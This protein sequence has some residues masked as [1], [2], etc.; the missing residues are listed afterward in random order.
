MKQSYTAY[1]MIVIL[2]S[3]FFTLFLNAQ[4]VE[5]RVEIIRL[6]DHPWLG[7]QISDASDTEGL[8]AKHG[9]YVNDVVADSPADS[10][11]LRIG[12]V[13]IRFGEVEI[14]EAEDLTRAVGQSE[15]NEPVGIVVIRDGREQRLSVT[16]R[17]RP[18]RHALRMPPPHDRQR[19]VI[20][21]N[22]GRLGVSV[23]NLSSQLR[24]Y[25]KVP[26]GSGVLVEKVHAETP[27]EKAGIRAGDVI[28]KVGDRNIDT[29]R[30]L[31]RVLSTYDA[32]EQI[33]V[34]LIREGTKRTVTAQLE[35]RSSTEFYIP[36][37][38]REDL[39]FRIFGPGGA[40]EFRRNLEESI[41]PGLEDLRIQLKEH[42]NEFQIKIPDRIREVSRQI[43]I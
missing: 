10:A 19:I 27:A 24:E 22:Y 31:R 42:F 34:E 4:K 32:G 30:R 8:S 40:E 38:D 41:R 3:L 14:L 33:Q 43:T 28:I 12:D 29:A 18:H 6:S 21:Q 37:I 9:A 26:E 2:C 13:I 7:V 16:L 23:I 11:G 25:F 17:D 35:E 36:D 20:T 1:I 39:E 15:K 5:R